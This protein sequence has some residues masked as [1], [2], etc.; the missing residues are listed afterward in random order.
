MNSQ[1]NRKSLSLYLSTFG[2][3]D[4]TATKTNRILRHVFTNKLAKDFN[5][6][7]QNVSKE[8]FQKLHLNTVLIRSVQIKSPATTEHD[9]Q[10]AIKIWLKHAPERLKED[11]KRENR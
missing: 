8:A 7:G 9:I 6:A 5:Y 11:L 4:S 3:G 2:G 1:Q 10:K